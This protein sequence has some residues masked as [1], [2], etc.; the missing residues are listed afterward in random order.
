MHNYSLTTANEVLE[1]KCED[2]RKQVEEL[3]RQVD[4]ERRKTERILQEQRARRDEA[5]RATASL[6]TSAQDNGNTKDQ[7]QSQQK[8]CNFF[9]LF[10]KKVWITRS[11]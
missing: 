2:L 11:C 5:Q 9:Y 6:Q 3:N 4:I 10:L 7:C 1:E 8:V